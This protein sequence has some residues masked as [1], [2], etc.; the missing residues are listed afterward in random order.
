MFLPFLDHRTGPEVRA[1][2]RYRISRIPYQMR[3]LDWYS[4]TIFYLE[5]VPGPKTK[6]LGEGLGHC[7]RPVISGLGRCLGRRAPKPKNPCWQLFCW[8]LCP[9]QMTHLSRDS[10]TW[11]TSEHGPCHFALVVWLLELWCEGCIAKLLNTFCMELSHK[12]NCTA[13]S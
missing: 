5:S 1:S 6:V 8:A 13:I 12:L 2:T 9:R 10:T 4:V 11:T 7:P 3:N